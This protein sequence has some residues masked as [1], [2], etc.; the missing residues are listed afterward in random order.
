[1]ADR[2]RKE[3]PE[4]LRPKTWFEFEQRDQEAETRSKELE[5]ETR[6]AKIEQQNRLLQ[7]QIHE[8]R[9]RRA[10]ATTL[11]VVFIITIIFTAGIILL[12]GFRIGGFV[13]ET[14]TINLLIGATIGEIV[15]IFTATL[16]GVFSCKDETPQE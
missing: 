11:L 6:E 7:E 5:V 4:I 16:R 13:I 10:I 3:D 9:R 15:T 12:S 2:F 14:S 1:M 8:S